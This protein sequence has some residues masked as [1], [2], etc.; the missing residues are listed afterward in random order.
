MTADSAPSPVQNA[1]PPAAAVTML[2]GATFMAV[3]AS[4][5]LLIAIAGRFVAMPMALLAVEVLATILGLFLFGSFRF[6]IHKNALTYG[7]LL[8]IVA[9]FTGLST[10]AWHVEILDG[11]W[12]V[13]LRQ[14]VLSFHG[15]DD[16]IHADTMLFILGL[17][18][19]VAVIAQTRLL[20]GVAFRLL[21]RNHGLLL[22]TVLSVTAVVAFA[23]GIL[24]G[25][26]MV[27]LT[28]RTLVIIMMLAAA[29]ARRCATPSWSARRSPRS[30]ACG[31]RMASRPT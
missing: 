31:L 23:S 1:V 4:A 7:M 21:R 27:G 9:T 2:P 17:T 8:V 6:Q 14:H 29:P 26:S 18:F 20:E 16:L 25:V 15:L 19:F 30:A 10:S 22:P 5:A 3:A 24:D 13:W 28:I 12:G 11:G